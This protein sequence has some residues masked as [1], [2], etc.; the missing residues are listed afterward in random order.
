MTNGM[1]KRKKHIFWKVLLI[2]LL[3]MLLF[4]A[5]VAI[6][7]GS[8]F[9]T[10]VDMSLFGMDIADSTTRFY[11][12]D[13]GIDHT[14][15]ETKIVELD[16]TLKGARHI[17]YCD[18]ADIPDY[19][20][21]AF[22]AIEDKR[23]FEHEGIDLYRSVAAAA[24]YV[25]GFDDRFGA[26]TITQQL[27][28]N[29]TGNDEITV[30]RKLQE[31]LY[32]YDLEKKM[33]KEEILACYLN[34]INLSRGCYGVGAAAN[35]YFSKSVS[36]LDL[37]ECACIA[38]ITNSPTYYD[39]IRNP[40]N[41]KARRDLIL[42]AMY[43]QGYLSESE[44]AKAYGADV[45]LRV[46]EKALRERVNSWYVDM[47]VEDVIDDLAEQYGYSRETAARMVYNGGL[48]IV[49]AMDLR[50]QT[51]LDAYYA[52][53]A[54]F[55]VGSE[56]PQCSMIL[57]NPKN[58]D[59][60]GVAGAVG[61]KQGNRVQNYATDAKRP[62]GSTVKPLSVYA[63]ALEDGRITYATVYDDVPVEFIKTA[64]GYQPWPHNANMVYR[65]LTNVNYALANSL[66]TVALKVLDDVGLERSF[67]FLHDTLQV[68]SVIER[69]P[70]DGGG[71]LTDKAPAALALGQMNHGV[72][73]REMTAA[74]SIFPGKG[75]YSEPRSYY[76][77]YDS[78]GRELL[79]NDATSTYAISAAN[80][81][82]MT[83]MLEHVISTGTAKAITLD[84]IID[85]AGKTGTTQN[86]CDKWF[87]AYTPYCLCGVWYGYEYPKPIGEA[88][89][90]KYLEVW[91]D[92]MVDLHRS[93][94]IPKGGSRHFS[95]DPNV[96]KATFCRDS[97]CLMTTDCY[98]DPRN[99]RAEV[100]YFVK[101][102]EPR[103][104]CTCHTAI[105][106]DTE[107]G[108]V[109]C[110][111]CACENV[112]RVGLLRVDRHFPIQIYVSDAQYTCRDL[113]SGT[114]PVVEEGR[115]YFAARMGAHDYCGI[116]AGSEQYNRACAKHFNRA[117]W[118][119]K[120]HMETAETEE[121]ETANDP[122]QE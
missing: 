103:R 59:I 99:N 70:L 122:E 35:I 113:P 95:M 85:V 76:K 50:V 91:N 116:S 22:V 51:T 101:G 56:M 14:Y 119:L 40:E 107:G 27:V 68:K 72:T 110:E 94:Y 7:I 120:K 13:S 23:F 6:Y 63:P 36:E 106:Y 81:D 15:D 61:E 121:T 80:A 11:Y 41:N 111:G 114:L 48:R 38:A 25:L 37:V 66:N 12:C 105:N 93:Y 20:I 90:Y 79:N 3:L 30:K 118:I 71:Y 24:N 69:E 57:I 43:E 32:A 77:V 73:L 96:I 117:E 46:N 78:K 53:T 74:Y 98:L 58:G 1:R 75:Q 34:V 92:V 19:L 87:I 60:L 29:V 44:Y 112:T 9:E 86:N 82:I 52:N 4:A 65:G 5:G 26:S 54:H 84:S 16:E 42:T 28:K 97:G 17:L 104:Y 109:V 33:S 49:T 100:G 62:S 108:G 45:V 88:E 39:P 8:T 67:S 64:T 89:K 10:E 31:I 55:R 18:Y 102:T 83:K 47:V 115:P 2:L 21:K